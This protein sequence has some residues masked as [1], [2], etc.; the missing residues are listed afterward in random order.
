MITSGDIN[1]AFAHMSV[2]G[3]NHVILT[4]DNYNRLIRLTIQHNDLQKA[5]LTFEHMKRRQVL[6]N[7]VTFNLLLG[8]NMRAGKT[9]RV[10]EL[11]EEMKSLGIHS[12]SNTRA[13][14]IEHASSYQQLTALLGKLKQHQRTEPVLIAA[15]RAALRLNQPSLAFSFLN[16]SQ[17]SPVFTYKLIEACAQ[18]Q[19]VDPTLN[20]WNRLKA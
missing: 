1:R 13:L 10:T 3:E 16:Q 7:S 19:L 9:K 2:M 4:C 12:N 6:P 8:A 11:L 14:L 20:V 17:V 5:E 18:M 15:S